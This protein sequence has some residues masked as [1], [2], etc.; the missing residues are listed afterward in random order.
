MPSTLRTVF[1]QIVRFAVVVFALYGPL[2]ATAQAVTPLARVGEIDLRQWDFDRDGPVFLAGDWQFFWR[3][4]IDPAA[5]AAGATAS[6]AELPSAWTGTVVDGKT[7]GS[8]GYASYRLQVNCVGT[9]GL[10]MALPVQ[11]SAVRMFVNGREVA[12]QGRPGSDDN[13]SVPAVAQQYVPLVN[14]SCPLNVVAHI[15]NFDHRRGGMV[16]GIRL[17]NSGQMQNLRDAGLLRDV[18]ALGGLALLS[19]FPI[20]FFIW[21][22]R[23]SAPLYF[24]LFCLCCSV[25]IAMSG[26]RVALPI[27]GPLGWDWYLRLTFLSLYGGV[28]MIG[29]FVHAAYPREFGRWQIRVVNWLGA[30]GALL[31][32]LT[33]GSIFTLSIPALVVFAI[34]MVCYMTWVLARTSW[35]HRGRG[36]APILLGGFAVLV[37][38]IGH[39]LVFFRYLLGSFWGPYGLLLFA[40]APGF[41]L[42]RRM[43]RALSAEELRTIE[44]RERTN[45]LV[46]ATK[47]GLLDWDATANVVTYSDRYKEMLGYPAQAASSELPD[48]YSLLLPDDS[49]A[50][51]SRFIG[52]MRDRSVTSGTRHHQ[53]MEYR[54]RRVDG[55]FVWVHAEGMALMGT[56]GRTLRFICSFIDISDAKRQASQ[57]AEQVE[58]T[59]TEQRRLDLVVRGA[60]VGMVDWDGTTHETYYSPR[61]REILGHAPDANTSGWPDYFKV[62]IHPD[63]RER[64]IRRWIP[65]IKGKGPEGPFGD[66]YSPEEYRLLRRDG[67]HVWVQVSGMA[68]RDDQGFVVRWIAAIIDISERHAQ[69]E[70][71]RVSHDQVAAQ[72]SEMAD[73]VKYINDLVNSLPIALAMTDSSGRYVFANRTWERYFNL[74]REL[75]IGRTARELL[76]SVPATEV[77]ALNKAALLAGPQ[78]QSESVVVPF[79]GREYTETRT[80][81]ADGRGEAVGVV[82]ASIDVTERRAMEAALATEQRRIALVVRASK[83]GIIDW[84]GLTRTVFYSPRLRE[85]LGYTAD[86]DT[87]AWPDYFE[88]VHPDDAKRVQ[89]A[90]SNH[91][92]GRGPAG[93]EE[94]H[95][96][97][98]YRLRCADGSFVWVQGVGVSVRDSK[99]YATRFIGSVTNVTER[100]AQE[101]ALHA[102]H[103]QIATQAMQLESQ[104]EALKENVRLREEVERIA[105][106]DIKT[107]LN[108]IIAVPRL[109]REERR[110]T[111][112]ADELLGIVERAG[113]RILSMVNL[114]LDLYKMEQGSY[115]FRPDAVDLVDLVDKVAVDIR[116]HAASKNV[117]LKLASSSVRVC[118]W[119]EELLCY[120]LIANLLKNAVE[121]SPEGTRVTVALQA[122]EGSEYVVLRIHNDGAVP[123]A[124]KGTFFTKYATAGKASGTG[125]GTYS[126]RLMALTQDGDVTMQTSESDGTTL[127]VRLR[128][129]PAGKVPP[130]A[131]HAIHDRN[132]QPKLLDELLPLRVLLVDDDEYNLLIVRRF[133]PCPPLTVTTAF[134][135]RMAL[136]MVA[137]EAPDVMFMDL[138]MPVMGG[139][140][141]IGLLRQQELVLGRPHGY[142]V[143]LSSH[144]DDGIRAR[145]LAAGFDHYLAKPVTRELIQQTLLDYAAL[146]R[147]PAQAGK[148]EVTKV[149]PATASGAH[150]SV[151]IDPEVFGLLESFLPSRY[152]LLNEMDQAI[153]Q[154]DREG[155]RRLAHQLGGSMDL[156]GF[157]WA[158]DVCKGIETA[159]ESIEIPS[160]SAKVRDLRRHLET[161]TIVKG[162]TER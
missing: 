139:L 10:T 63:D 66:F 41:M 27:L 122:D 94:F 69:Q 136:D 101:E 119:A 105:R 125:L 91:I 83:A 157:R 92:I 52:E 79:N 16:R 19:V 44:Q 4:F 113:Y 28:T 65:F 25:F 150:D 80:V 39:D 20:L 159:A 73:R 131:R 151:V 38:A 143:V 103:N 50:V 3:Q 15:S 109:L 154:G 112:E 155:L 121:A 110:L 53:P 156:Y 88:I 135:G 84:D 115:I 33:P 93:A 138:D 144:D 146:P 68:V 162:E 128:A 123:A 56:D 107:P 42:A 124:V 18:G 12:H 36:S 130:T 58:R 111:A 11:H 133:L 17:G 54:M 49:K 140:E 127:L 129:A 40:F 74:D 72:A 86:A 1:V 134:N 89:Q 153:A 23:E 116:G 26:E 114:S 161:A 75:V 71:L 97:M 141:A 78:V 48:F 61:F 148:P 99:G 108:S 34:V 104:N 77:E 137:E 46:R 32:I 22:R 158:A 13:T 100:R 106:H 45:L 82:V 118:A 5:P 51:R 8:D 31:A 102:S 37:I 55:D 21:R 35:R 152:Q 126:A 132:Q 70:A 62:M 90:F 160:A 9:A 2:A 149:A 60:R 67:S 147:Q 95:N 30:A 117:V 47:A 85:L 142:V 76:G 57:M 81:M 96:A 64:V 59:R 29:R 6:F 7:L 120:S 24:G 43:L 145:C 87:S 14:A 98:D